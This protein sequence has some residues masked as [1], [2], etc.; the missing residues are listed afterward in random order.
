MSDGEIKYIGSWR[1]GGDNFM[2]DGEINDGEREII[3]GNVN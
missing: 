3:W 1:Y 2:N